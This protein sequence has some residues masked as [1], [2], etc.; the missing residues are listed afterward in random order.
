MAST[1]SWQNKPKESS[2]L[3]RASA[4]TVICSVGLRSAALGTRRYKGNS[5]DLSSQ[6]LGVMT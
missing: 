4:A 3:P 2:V 1:A 6:F 5:L